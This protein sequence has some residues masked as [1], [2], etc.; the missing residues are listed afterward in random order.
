MVASCYNRD[1]TW[2]CVC[3]WCQ[4]PEGV[5]SPR[6]DHSG[7]VLVIA[8]RGETTPSGVWH[9]QHK[10][11]HVWSLKY[12]FCLYIL[13]TFCYHFFLL[14]WYYCNKAFFMLCTLCCNIPWCIVYTLFNFI[15]PESLITNDSILRKQNSWGQHGA[16][17]GP[18]G[19]RWAPCW[20]HEPCYQALFCPIVWF[21]CLQ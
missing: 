17:M 2:L 9:Q 3:C 15:V 8:R 11:N 12:Y 20:P 16:H 18:V 13:P 14:W 21:A 19:P 7:C 1:Q 10:H 5:V 6:G 4:T